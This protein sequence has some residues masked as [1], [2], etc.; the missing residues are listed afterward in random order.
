MPKIIDYTGRK[1]KKLT[2]IK[3]TGKRHT[4]PCGNAKRIWLFKCDCGSE[5][6]FM[7]EKVVKGWNSSCGCSKSTRTK[8]QSLQHAAFTAGKNYNNGDLTEEDFVYLSEQD[9]FWCNTKPFNVLIHRSYENITWIANG[10]DRIDNDKP[11][12]RDNVVPCCWPCNNL[13]GELSIPDF[14]TKIQKIYSNR[15]YAI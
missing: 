15:I 2:A 10:L 11:H 5:V 13:R 9:C 3:F 1:Y 6:E 8:L 14:I 4:T 7:I 12:D